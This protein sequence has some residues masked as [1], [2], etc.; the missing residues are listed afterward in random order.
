MHVL[1][2]LYP[3]P[4][5]PTSFRSYYEERH[6]PLAAKLPG[7]V[8]HSHGY[9]TALGG[10]ASP[11]CVWRAEFPNAAALDAALGS[12][13]GAK[14]AADVANFSSAPPTLI[15]FDAR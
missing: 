10:G 15:R 8:S 7:L 5:D 4:A 3:A 12:E 6:V 2:V 13:I 11:F 9:P 1:M 14:V